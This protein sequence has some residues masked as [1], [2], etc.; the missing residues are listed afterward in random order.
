MQVREVFKVV[1]KKPKYFGLR[2][3][4]ANLCIVLARALKNLYRLPEY[5]RI[6][7]AFYILLLIVLVLV[8]LDLYWNR[9][10]EM[11]LLNKFGKDYENY[12]KRVRI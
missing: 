9:I 1:L 5:I 2:Y 12:K 8:I 3:I 7:S 4:E 11:N 10:D 6:M